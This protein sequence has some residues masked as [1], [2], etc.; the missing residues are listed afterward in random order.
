MSEFPDYIRCASD[1]KYFDNLP[2]LDVGKRNG[3]TDYIDYITVDDM[4]D[5]VMKGV[6]C[7]RRPFLAIKVN[8]VNDEGETKKMVGTFFQRYSDNHVSWAFGTC[9]ETNV[10]F[11]DSRVRPEHFEGLKKRL[12][13]LFSGS[14]LQNVNFWMGDLNDE[15]D[16]INGNGT[17]KVVLCE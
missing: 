9:Y 1:E 5:P 8:T 10:I 11:H 14:Q 15:V 12:Q 6:D 4:T 13:K 3:L 17:L 7:F 16:W 2:V